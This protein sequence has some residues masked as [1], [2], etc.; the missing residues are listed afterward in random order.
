MPPL[1]RPIQKARTAYFLFAEEKRAEIAA[2]HPGEGVGAVA[3]ETGQMWAALTEEE[4][5]P[6]HQQSAQE[7][8]R[9]A[10]ELETYK[11]DYHLPDSALGA[12]FSSSLMTTKKE[13]SAT[14]MTHSLQL[15]SARIR[16]ICKLDPDVKGISKE[17]LLL[18]TKSAEVFTKRLGME[19]VQVAALQN[20][21]KLLPQDIANVCSARE[22]F[23]FLKEDVRDLQQEMHQQQQARLTKA[24]RKS[25]TT[26]TTNNINKKQQQARGDDAANGKPLTDYFSAKQPQ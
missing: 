2:R 4:K 21:R 16:K 20:R 1:P 6:Y 12:L 26:T 22:Q 17:A 3:R 23:L 11:K 14:V 24:K 8:E 18:I 7:K 9:V 15:P 19:T 13:P 10:A 5:A 25:D